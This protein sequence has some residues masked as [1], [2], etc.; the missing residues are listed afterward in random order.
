MRTSASR[1]W[2]CRCSIAL[3]ARRCLQWRSSTFPAQ[4]GLRRCGPCAVEA[5]NRHPRWASLKKNCGRRPTFPQAGSGPAPLAVATSPDAAVRRQGA[6]RLRRGDTGRK[7]TEAPDHFV[8]P[9]AALAAGPA[10]GTPPKTRSCKIDNT[11]AAATARRRQR[12]AEPTLRGSNLQASRAGARDS[13]HDHRTPDSDNVNGHD[14]DRNTRPQPVSP[15]ACEEAATRAMPPRR[16]ARR[17]RPPPGPA[18][19]GKETP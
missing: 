3:P 2:A 6:A 15:E 1:T 7:M 18:A 14:P 17:D 16:G 12:L 8:A 13:S 11:Q 5:H 9:R 4:A 10:P 19:V